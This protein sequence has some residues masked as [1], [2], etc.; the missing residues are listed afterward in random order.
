MK[1]VLFGG[2]LVLCGKCRA[3]RAY[4]TTFIVIPADSRFS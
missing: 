1:R 4:E 2:V 3:V